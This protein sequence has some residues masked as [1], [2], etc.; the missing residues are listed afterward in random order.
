[1]HRWQAAHNRAILDVGCHHLNRKAIDAISGC[2]GL[3]DLFGFIRVEMNPLLL[4]K[5]YKD[6]FSR[7]W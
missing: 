2:Y 5:W 1:M 3:L 7:F 4:R 6:N